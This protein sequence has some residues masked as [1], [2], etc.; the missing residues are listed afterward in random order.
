MAAAVPE[1]IHHKESCVL[2]AFLHMGNLNRNPQHPSGSIFLLKQM[3]FCLPV[4]SLQFFQKSTHIYPNLL[5]G[6]S[7]PFTSQER[8]IDNHLRLT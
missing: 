2:R 4:A 3:L 1:C 8:G 5:G 7:A 6:N